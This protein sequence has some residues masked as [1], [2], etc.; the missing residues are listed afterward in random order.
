MLIP[1]GGYAV[2]YFTADNP[3]PGY[4]FLH[5]H[6]EVHQLEGMGVIISEAVDKATS[7]PEGMQQQC[8]NFTLSL[9]EFKRAQ[10][11]GAGTHFSDLKIISLC[12]AITVAVCHYIELF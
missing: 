4:W 1:F 9:E 5:C 8:G 10:R 11:G 2:L 12:L 7:P 6:I 3:W